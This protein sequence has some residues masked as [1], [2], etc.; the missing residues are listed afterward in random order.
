MQMNTILAE[1]DS[2]KQQN[3]DVIKQKKQKYLELTMSNQTYKETIVSEVI[4]IQRWYRHIRSKFV[5]RLILNQ[6]KDKHKARLR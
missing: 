6:A 5:F 2:L 1:Y 3:E 4:R